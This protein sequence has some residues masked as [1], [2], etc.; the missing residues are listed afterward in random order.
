MSLTASRLGV[1]WKLYSRT[2][3]LLG[4][5]TIPHQIAHGLT[6]PTVRHV[7]FVV[8]TRPPT[9]AEFQ[10]EP[11][12]EM[13][14]VRTAIIERDWQHHDGVLLHGITLEEIERQEGFAF[15]PGAGYLRSLI[16]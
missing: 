11:S 10:R 5:L 15:A 2:G 7:R 16:E 13:R 3:T 12:V 4:T 14:G 1:A 6:D 9:F 8:R